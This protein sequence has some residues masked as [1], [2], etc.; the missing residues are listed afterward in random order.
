[1]LGKL[2]ADFGGDFSGY[3][4]NMGEIKIWGCKWHPLATLR[5]L[6]SSSWIASWDS[7]WFC[8]KMACLLRIRPEYHDGSLQIVTNWRVCTFL[9]KSRWSP[10]MSK[11]AQSEIRFPNRVAAVH[12]SLVTQSE[13]CRNRTR[14][15]TNYD[16]MWALNKSSNFLIKLVPLNFNTLL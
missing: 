7:K 15:Q 10:N 5:M 8:R 16:H 3:G 11:A 6:K 1:M 12:A 2:G 14:G 9:D 13:T 4:S